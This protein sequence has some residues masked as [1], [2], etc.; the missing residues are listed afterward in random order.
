MALLSDSS[1]G[2][3]CPVKNSRGLTAVCPDS[4]GGFPFLAARQLIQM[5]TTLLHLCQ[6][7]QGGH[8]LGWFGCGQVPRGFWA[9]CV[10][11]FFSSL[12]S[13]SI[14]KAPKYCIPTENAFHCLGIQSS[15][16]KP[17]LCLKN[18]KP[19]KLLVSLCVFYTHPRALL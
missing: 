6:R 9:I 7:P 11:S 5:P 1:E 8:S 3:T 14:E 12:Y 2:K 16:P 18:K 10:V 13:C 4:L 15:L 19:F 17:D